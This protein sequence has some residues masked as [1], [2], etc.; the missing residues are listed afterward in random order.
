[1]DTNLTQFE[2]EINEIWS[3]EV[4]HKC[5]ISK[6]LID[7]LLN[8][9][10]SELQQFYLWFSLFE[11]NHLSKIF[12]VSTFLYQSNYFSQPLTFT[13]LLCCLEDI[14]SQ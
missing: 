7:S 6:S 10:S 14:P 3:F 12:E 5:A 4:Q 13:I 9:R 8:S 2:F 11:F 1:M